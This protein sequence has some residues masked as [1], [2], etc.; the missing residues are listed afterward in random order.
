MT[1]A[2]C[3]ANKTFDFIVA[4]QKPVFTP[5]SF[6]HT[7]SEQNPKMSLSVLTAL[8]AAPA[9]PSSVLK[10]TRPLHPV[11]FTGA[12]GVGRGRSSSP[13]FQT[14]RLTCPQRTHSLFLPSGHRFFLL[15]PAPP[16][17]SVLL[18]HPGDQKPA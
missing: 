4:S 7:R 1:H 10:L 11:S 8:S 3:L 14:L 13:R 17:A 16:Q 2:D 18:R 5:T 12:G 15:L 6:K 9:V